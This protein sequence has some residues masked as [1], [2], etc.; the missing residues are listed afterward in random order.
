MILVTGATGLLG[1]N[2]LASLKN[3]GQTVRAIHRGKSNMALAEK[4]LKRHNLSLSDVEWVEADVTDVYSIRDAM[5]GVE[6]VYHCAAVVS[7]NPAA[8]KHMFNVNVAGTANVVNA[9]VEADVKKLCHVSST[10]ALGRGEENI[11]ID[12][13]SHWTNSKHN[14]QYAISKYGAEREVWRAIE[15]GLNAVIVNP[16]VILGAGDWK[17]DSSRIVGQ[18]GKGL[19]FYPMGGNALVDVR[20]VASV[21][22]KLM[23]SSISRERFLV[24]SENKSYKEL[25]ALIADAMEKKK[26]QFAIN[27]PMSSLG[28]RAE[29]LRAKITGKPPVITREMMHSSSR[30]YRYSNEK[31]RKAI[32]Y[33]FIPL[34]KCVEDACAVYLEEQ[35][36]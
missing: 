36:R 26:P 35:K 29:W 33:D 21:M 15:E 28:W 9:A 16:C 27:K 6:Y 7:F 4:T 30:T 1:T 8:A 17:G 25:F 24:V 11:L 23:E 31:I 12:E 5:Q 14:S 13:E 32:G 22:M 3:S 34:K 20:D 19:L 2:L 10:A 18:V